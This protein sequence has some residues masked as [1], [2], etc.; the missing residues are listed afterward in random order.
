MNETANEQLSALMDGE[1]P[2]DE[3]RFLLRGLDG[4]A[5]LAL[6]WSRYHIARAVLQRQY[7]PAATGDD[8]FAAAVMVRLE[9][10]PAQRRI[11]RIGR[12]AG[13]GAIAAAVAVVALMATRP[14]GESGAL[15]AART[16]MA[17]ITPMLLP[18][19]QPAAAS[20][21]RQQ[22]VFVPL[23]AMPATFSDAQPAS[24]ESFVPRYATNPRG[25]VQNN[26][27]GTPNG[28]VPYVLMVGSRPKPEVQATPGQ[29]APPP[30][31]HQQQQ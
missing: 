16:E 7:L 14:A 15:P 29:D 18:P 26:T 12:W 27:D 17:A 22:P 6:R 30:Q 19:Q 25:P 21:A 2:R 11:A 23:P 8:R 10:A 13:G 24:F 1:L 28:F 20:Q 5:G 31:Q 3:L 9:P 4:D